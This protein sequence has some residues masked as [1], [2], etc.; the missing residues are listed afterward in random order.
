MPPASPLPGFGRVWRFTMLIFSTRARAPSALTLV[1][2]PVRPLSLP[3][4]TITWSPFLILRIAL[5]SIPGTPG[6]QHFGRQGNNLHKLRRTQLARHRP[7]DTGADRLQ[8]VVQQ[9]RCIGIEAYD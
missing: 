8:L 1:T 7:E 5:S 2:L 6:L 3:A 4:I 9:H